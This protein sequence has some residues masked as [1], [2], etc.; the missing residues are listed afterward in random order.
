MKKLKQTLLNA[1][2]GTTLAAGTKTEI[3][4]QCG[5]PTAFPGQWDFSPAAMADLVS[6]LGG[7]ATAANTALELRDLLFR[8]AS[9]RA[10]LTGFTT[11]TLNDLTAYFGSTP[12]TNLQTALFGLPRKKSY[13]WRNFA[14]AGA[15]N[16]EVEVYVPHEIY[17]DGSSNKT[18]RYAVFSFQPYYNNVMHLGR[19][20]EG[21]AAHN[22]WH[23]V[24]GGAVTKTGFGS[25]Y[26]AA[27]AVL[28]PGPNSTA[29]SETPT[30]EIKFNA[31][32]GH[33]LVLRSYTNVN[34]GFALV[35]LDG[36]Y[37][38]ADLKLPTVQADEIETVSSLTDQGSNW[39]CT[40]STKHGFSAGSTV[41]LEGL[42]GMTPAT[43]YAKNISN[44]EETSFTFTDTGDLTGTY[45]PNSG[46][47]GYFSNSDVGKRYVS[48]YAVQVAWYDEHTLLAEGLTDGSHSVWLKPTGTSLGGSGSRAYVTGVAGVTHDSTPDQSVD[49]SMV[50]LREVCNPRSSYSAMVSAI[51]INSSGNFLGEVHGNE[52]EAGFAWYVDGRAVWPVPGGYASGTVIRGALRSVLHNP[53]Y[54]S[55][56]ADKTSDYFFSAYQRDACRVVSEVEWRLPATGR[57]VYY[58]M[59]PIGKRNRH[60]TPNPI[61]LNDEFDRIYFG[62][63]SI[64]GL[65]DDDNTWEQDFNDVETATCYHSATAHP[66]RGRLRIDKAK[67]V[68]NWA[69]TGASIHFASQ[70]RTEGVD[71]VYAARTFPN[72][73]EAYDVGDVHESDTG[74]H[75]FRQSNTSIDVE[76]DT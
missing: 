38:S 25:T 15:R 6:K 1:I 65:G 4:D 40:T 13:L 35:A 47:V 33:T 11:A 62:S 48:M 49:H 23:N 73:E 27:P 21:A 74:Y 24:G 52:A 2:D 71:K 43:Y 20:K 36:S 41:R 22:V 57:S 9:A 61:Y 26:S 51:E 44:I 75:V 66:T 37:T 76:Q 45:V 10:T 39:L 28:I 67:N 5:G 19:L 46:K 18:V 72:A 17:V 32:T 63:T 70:D 42:G 53:G 56:V 16:G 14:T 68:N 7:D 8:G 3:I 12:A 50:Y 69:A 55:A 60:V 54:V 29:W 59:L 34:G 64:G 31:V 58:G 30:D